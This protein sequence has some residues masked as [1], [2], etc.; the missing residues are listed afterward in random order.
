MATAALA[1]AGGR[2]GEGIGCSCQGDASVLS[3]TI[4]ALKASLTRKMPSIPDVSALREK[5][6]YIE[7]ASGHGRSCISG[8]LPLDGAA[9][10]R[11]WRF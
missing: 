8:S 11:G 10:G 2:T 3:G 6:A 9:L 5:E 1:A 4:I 7:K